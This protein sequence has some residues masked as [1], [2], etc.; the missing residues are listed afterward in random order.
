MI[1][2]ITRKKWN[3]MLDREKGLVDNLKELSAA[4]ENLHRLHKGLYQK[5]EYEKG[6]LTAKIDELEKRLRK[7]EHERNSALKKLPRTWH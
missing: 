7:S 1:K 2:I 6:E 3:Q 5:Y 4:H